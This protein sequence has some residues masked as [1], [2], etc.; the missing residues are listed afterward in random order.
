MSW[1]CD[2]VDYNQRTET[3]WL[4]SRKPEIVWVGQDGQNFDTTVNQATDTL[5]SHIER[6]KRTVSPLVLLAYACR[7][8][9]AIKARQDA[10]IALDVF[11]LICLI[12]NEKGW[13]SHPV[14]REF[15]NEQRTAVDFAH[16]W[17]TV[18]SPDQRTL[19]AAHIVR[20]CQSEVLL[21]TRQGHI[22][23]N[24]PLMDRIYQTLVPENM[25]QD[26]AIR[27]AQAYG[28]A[29]DSSYLDQNISSAN[30]II[31]NAERLCTILLPTAI[32]Y[33]DS[34]REIQKR[35]HVAANPAPAPVLPRK[36]R[37]TRALV[38][39]K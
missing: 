3:A 39:Q 14:L 28:S 18:L 37:N 36:I 17:H 8:D 26:D 27:A 6:Q 23:F 30:Y 33:R 29:K 22:N 32:P 12:P 4:T 19:I 2:V 5:I 9:E 25:T 24:W 31:E 11:C 34:L 21:Q 13:R 16:F 7:A 1:I 35:R 20:T 10:P 38:A 15:F